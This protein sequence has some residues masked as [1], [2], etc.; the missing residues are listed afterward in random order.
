MNNRTFLLIGAAILVWYCWPKKAKQ[1]AQADSDRYDTE[2]ET[3]LGAQSAIYPLDK[4][5]L[6]GDIG[7][8]S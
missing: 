7:V 4:P 6:A 1:A 2:A 8:Y 5:N 3:I